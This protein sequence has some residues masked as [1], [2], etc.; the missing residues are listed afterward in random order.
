MKPKTKDEKN[1]LL[2]LES[3]AVDNEGRIDS[4]KLNDEDHAILEKWMASQYAE[5]GR[6]AFRDVRGYETLWVH[7]SEK[8][9]IDAHQ[10]RKER[11]DRLWAKKN[12][13]TTAEARVM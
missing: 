10:L 3:M 11:A 13:L 12:Y 8:A 4:R 5:T 2:F 6:I 1:L 9:H 7:L